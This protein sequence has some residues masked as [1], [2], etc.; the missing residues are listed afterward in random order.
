[1]AYSFSF[2]RVFSIIST[3]FYSTIQVISF[4]KIHTHILSDK[5]KIKKHFLIHIYET[6]TNKISTKVCLSVYAVHHNPLEGK[7]LM[8]FI[9]LSR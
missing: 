4:N 1:M 6:C 9:F 2:A 7:Y 8:H 5:E 3:Q